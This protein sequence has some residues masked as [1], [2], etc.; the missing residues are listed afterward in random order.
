MNSSV[1]PYRRGGTGMKGGAIRAILIC[2]LL[3]LVNTRVGGGA[4][5]DQTMQI[6]KML[7]TLAH[8]GAS[9]PGGSLVQQL[10]DSCQRLI[11][12]SPG[13]KLSIQ[14]WLFRRQLQTPQPALGW[15][16]LR[17]LS[18]ARLRRCGG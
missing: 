14:L 10:G 8:V 2:L 6:T 7:M 5:R 15:C 13:Q 12:P 4:C 9:E 18:A 11:R 17:G 3:V 1:P 16:A